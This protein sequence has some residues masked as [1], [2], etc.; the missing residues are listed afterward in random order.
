[1]VSYDSR[2]NE[3]M[4]TRGW[5]VNVNNVAYRESLGGE[6][7]FDA[8]RAEIRYFLPHGDGNVFAIRQ[9]NNFTKDAPTLA[10]AAVQLRGYKVGQYNGIYMSSIEVEERWRL[11]KNGPQHSSEGSPVSTAK[12]RKC[13][14]ARTSFP[15]RASACSTF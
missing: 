2:D 7:D 3:N 1:M 12:A 5:L 13:R 9:L 10:R 14:I 4:P 15:P 6:E 8:I 11:A